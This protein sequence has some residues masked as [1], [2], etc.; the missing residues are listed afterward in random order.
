[1]KLFFY[2]TAVTDIQDMAP[3]FVEAEK[4]SYDYKV[5]LFDCLERKR[6][7]FNFDV[8]H[9][10]NRISEYI[11]IN[12]SSE[13][14]T[15]KNK[16]LFF[17]K[18]QKLDFEKFYLRESPEL[19]FLQ[20]IYHKYP[21]WV[22]IANR[23]KVVMFS[24]HHDAAKH[25]LRSPYEVFLNIVRRKEEI[26]FYKKNPPQWYIIPS[27]KKL[28]EKNTKFDSLY[29]GNLRAESALH[30][31]SVESEIKNPP[32]KSCLVVATQD[33]G[34][35]NYRSILK[36][37]NRILKKLRIL[38]Y[39][40][41][42]KARLKGYPDKKIPFIEDLEVLPDVIIGN[43][44]SIPS[45][46][47][48]LAKNCKACFSL[49]TSTAYWDLSKINPNSCIVVPDPPGEREERV[50][51][52]YYKYGDSE[53]EDLK[54]FYASENDFDS[55]VEKLLNCNKIAKDKYLKNNSL[56]SA[57][58]LDKIESMM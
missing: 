26:V 20:N 52:R 47:I 50:I 4:R 28:I 19:V 51:N 14:M 18:T 15:I 33:R 45:S 42:W 36:T 7:F 40:I 11:S 53:I 16:I 44:Y 29:L 27:N 21:A 32:E 35:H 12:T 25:T 34:G 23:S 10:I 43:D 6:Q 58:I 56:T 17:N 54:I 22:P 1:M 38:G 49:Q 46:I 8:Q 13:V 24:M 48:Y 5:V 3:I 2:I 30:N 39:K 37:A 57:R 41:Y 9:W 31:F 55:K